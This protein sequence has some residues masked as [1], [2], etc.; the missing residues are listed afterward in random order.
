MENKLD[1]PEV[2]PHHEAHYFRGLLTC[3]YCK[4]VFENPITLP[5]GN[6]VCSKD[7]KDLY[8][9][10]F[11]GHTIICYFC[12]TEHLY[13]HYP[14]NRIVNKFLENNLANFNLGKTYE[15]AKKSLDD[16]MDKMNEYEKLINNPAEYL[17][18][19]FE[20]IEK[21]IKHG[22]EKVKILSEEK[23]SKMLNDLLLFKNEC[24]NSLDS[25]TLKYLPD[26]L[27]KTKIDAIKENLEK[28]Y[29][30]LD[31][32]LGIHENKWG[33]IYVDS[34]FQNSDLEKRIKNIKKC[35]FLDINCTFEEKHLDLNDNFFG[36]LKLVRIQV[37]YL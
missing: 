11:E 19:Y 8:K 21:E 28:W 10:G 36:E 37:K 27:D 33:K 1:V 16:V 32:P 22:K 18:E 9:E 20:K 15:H 23:C 6:T 30:E 4:K 7:V 26:K 17:Y 29:R 14:P 24:Q 12:G 5:C 35:I 34:Q 13:Y 3:E 2:R 25:T 31:K